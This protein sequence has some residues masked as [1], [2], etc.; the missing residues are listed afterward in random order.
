MMWQRVHNSTASE[1][2]DTNGLL[3]SAIC[4]ITTC[5]HVG[6]DRL[7]YLRRF[8]CRKAR[9]Q[10]YVVAERLVYNRFS[11][12]AATER[13]N[14]GVVDGLLNALNDKRLEISLRHGPKA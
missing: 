2:A 9:Q 11:D 1:T 3:D 13:S 7:T 6:E 14:N 5:S 12:T 4:T 8:K 10:E